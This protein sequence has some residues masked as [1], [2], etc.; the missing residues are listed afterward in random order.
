[1]SGNDDRTEERSRAV[2]KLE[3]G[4]DVV[5]GGG[6]ENEEYLDTAAEEVVPNVVAEPRSYTNQEVNDMTPDQAHAA[7]ARVLLTAPQ[8]QRPLGGPPLSNKELPRRLLAVAPI[9][10]L[11]DLVMLPSSHVNNLAR[12][13]VVWRASSPKKSYFNK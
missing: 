7:A 9:G 2:E 3:D 13:S 5:G 8:I 10:A 6:G 11:E 4:A 1:M 12:C